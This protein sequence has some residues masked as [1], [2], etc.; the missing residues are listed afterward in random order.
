MKMQQDF[1]LAE[2]NFLLLLFSKI[3][4]LLL[5]PQQAFAYSNTLWWQKNP[6]NNLT[7]VCKKLVFLHVNVSWHVTED[8]SKINVNYSVLKVMFFKHF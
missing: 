4:L 8:I 1:C 7:S 5:K 6:V 3:T 2:L